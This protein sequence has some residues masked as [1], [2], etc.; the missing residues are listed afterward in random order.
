LKASW[1]SAPTAS[2]FR[3]LTLALREGNG[4]RFIGH[5]GTG[6]SREVL[7]DLHGNLIELKTAKSPFG[8]KVKTKRNYVGE[9]PA[10]RG[11]E[12]TE[13]IGEM[14]HPSIGDFAKA[15]K[16]RLV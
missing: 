11:F 6:F 10:R 2:R 14:R 16:R 5:V 1:Q 4:W 12:F 15:G 3:A 13:W 9:T 8:K 7:E